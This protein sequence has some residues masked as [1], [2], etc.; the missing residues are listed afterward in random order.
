MALTRKPQR[1]QGEDA[2]NE[3]QA[4]ALVMKGGSVASGGDAEATTDTAGAD[5]GAFTF[6]VSTGLL[7]RI[8]AT[9]KARA[10]KT[11]RQTWLLEAAVEKLE[12]EEQGKL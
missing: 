7:K 5:T 2:I 9:R 3:A 4:L 11:S 6:R 10:V 8:D 12:R 1:P